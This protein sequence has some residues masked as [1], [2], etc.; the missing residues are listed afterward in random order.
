MV[1]HVGGQ[2][3]WGSTD[4]LDTDVGMTVDRQIVGASALNAARSGPSSAC[5][6]QADLYAKGWNDA[7]VRVDHVAIADLPR[8]AVSLD[9]AVWLHARTTGRAPKRR[10]TARP[11]STRT[12]PRSSPSRP[13]RGTRG[14]RSCP[15]TRSPGTAPASPTAHTLTTSGHRNSPQAAFG[16][17]LG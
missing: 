2:E 8:Y 12:W 11:G 1:G 15:A 17:L 6:V 3:T 4:L 7:G 5:R 10:S 16:D 9:Q 14:S 13:R